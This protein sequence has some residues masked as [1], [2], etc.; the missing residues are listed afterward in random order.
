M[1]AKVEEE[2]E[3]KVVASREEAMVAKE[4]IQEVVAKEEEAVEAVVAN[5]ADLR[6]PVAGTKVEAEQVAGL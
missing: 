6:V 1:V 3:A 5:V 4:E 2:V